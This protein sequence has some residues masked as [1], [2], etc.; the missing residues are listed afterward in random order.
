MEVE[1]RACPN[2]EGIEFLNGACTRCGRPI[3]AAAEY[4]DELEG[5]AWNVVNF[6]HDEYGDLRGTATNGSDLQR[7]IVELANA[8]RHFHYD[9]DGCLDEDDDD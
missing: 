4:T 1:T 5:L 3:Q 8:L 9:G 7:A 2:C 6:A